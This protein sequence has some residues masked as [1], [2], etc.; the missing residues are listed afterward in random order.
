MSRKA[1]LES[2]RVNFGRTRR[3]LRKVLREGVWEGLESSVG[4]GLG[5]Y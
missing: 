1:C 3:R 2:V 5:G 4:E